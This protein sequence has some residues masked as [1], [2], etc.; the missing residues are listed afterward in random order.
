LP[1]A[2]MLTPSLTTVHIPLRPLGKLGASRL[3]A[4]L[5]R[6]EIPLTETL[7][8]SVIERASTRALEKTDTVN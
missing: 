1:M 2:R 8:V 4:A 7:S 6:E 5:N 3:L